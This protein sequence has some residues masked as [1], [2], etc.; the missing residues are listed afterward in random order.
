M[1][2]IPCKARLPAVG[3][4]VLCKLQ[5]CHTGGIQEH[6]LVKVRESDC[7]WRT[8]DDNSEL[9]YDWNVLEWFEK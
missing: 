9:S 6:E 5:H 3:S 2:W 4:K 1:A 7:S 8:A